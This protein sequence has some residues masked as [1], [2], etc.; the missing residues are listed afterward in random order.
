[1][2]SKSAYKSPALLAIYKVFLGIGILEAVLAARYLFNIPSKTQAVFLAGFSRQ[3]IGAG[4]VLLLLSGVYIFLLYDAFRSKKFLKFL[5]SRLEIIFFCGYLAHFYQVVA[6]NR[7][8]VQS[9]EQLIFLVPGFSK[10]GLLCAQH[11]PVFEL[12]NPYGN[13][14]RLGMSDQLENAHP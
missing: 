14:D 5:T 3:R 11:L 9:G 4:G 7:N 2:E 13:I 6:H 12:G 1:M 10:V 8:G